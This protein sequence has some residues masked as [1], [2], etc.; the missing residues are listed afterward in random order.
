MEQL[1]L[2]AVAVAV[3]MANREQITEVVLVALV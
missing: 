2:A 1:T 3:H